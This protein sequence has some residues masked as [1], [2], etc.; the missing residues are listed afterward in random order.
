MWD[1][2]RPSRGMIVLWRGRE[3]SELSRDELIEACQ[4]IAEDLQRE[5][6]WSNTSFETDAA[7]SNALSRRTVR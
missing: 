1:D 3:P 4:D 6:R 2:K 7:F 5:R